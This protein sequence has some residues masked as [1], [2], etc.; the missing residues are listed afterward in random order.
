MYFTEHFWGEIL[1]KEMLAVY[2]FSFIFL[3]LQGKVLTHSSSYAT[4]QTDSLV[5]LTSSLIGK[6]ETDFSASW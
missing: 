2:F 3:Y 5:S 1:Y 4:S 6:S